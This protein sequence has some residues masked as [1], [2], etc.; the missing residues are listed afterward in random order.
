MKVLHLI[1]DLSTGGA[2]MMLYKLLS[3][4][5]SLRFQN[6]VVSLTDKGTLGGHIEKMGISVFALGMRREAPNPLRLWQLLRIL[7]K[8][9]PNILQ[10]WLY[11]ADLLGLLMGKLIHVPVIAWNLR[12]SNMDMTRYSKLS[13]FVVYASAKLSSFPNIVL[14]NSKAGLQLHETLGYCPARWQ[15]IPN[16]FDIEQFHPDPESRVKLR[17]ELGLLKDTLLIGFVAR[18]D[19]MKDHA[20]FLQ[21]ASLLLKDYSNAHF[22]LVGGGVDQSNSELAKSIISLDIGNNVHLLGE[23]SDIPNITAALDIAS[24]SSYGE[25]F[26]NVVGEA[27][28]CAV[29]CVVTDVGDSALLV[30][31]TGKVVP[32]K[33]PHA[34]AGAWR[35]L[36]DIGPEG[37]K[38][39][40]LAARLRIKENFSLPAIVARYEELYEELSKCAE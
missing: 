26:P 7:Q 28:A 16:G 34:L 38:Q 9:R 36:I 22:I 27:M 33:N 19:P 3:R 21:A 37:R 40:G 31:D 15:L 5:D 4:M 13:S 24:S 25:G 11:H 17:K 6:I 18:F 30:G 23:R 32:P 35:E 12:C 8:E 39:L 10:T 1:T 29:P 20:N 2:E 14:V